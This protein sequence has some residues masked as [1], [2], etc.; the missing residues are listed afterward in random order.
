MPKDKSKSINQ[1]LDFDKVKSK[2]LSYKNKRVAVV[3]LG[4]TG[5]ALYRFLKSRG[6]KV[7]GLDRDS[8]LQCGIQNLILGEDYLKNL[9]QFDIIFVS[10]GVPLNLPEL[11]N[12]K[13]RG[14]II[15]SEI[16]L[17]FDLCPAKIIGITGTNGKTTTVTLLGKLLKARKKE[18]IWIGG[19]IGKPLIDKLDKIKKKDLV[20]LELSSFQLEN[21]TK[22]PFI[23]CILNITPDHLDR[24]PDFTS[25]L[26]AKANIFKY[27]NP[28]EFSVF[29]FDDPA[30]VNL[31]KIASSKVIFTSLY[32]DL[33]KG[34]FK[35]DK[36]IISTIFKRKKLAE[37]SDLKLPGD[38][39]LSNTLSALAIL[40]LIDPKV[41]PEL[42]RRV[43]KNFKGLEHRI[44]F[45]KE[46]K[47]V[48]YFN[49][50]KATTPASTI[51]ALKAF[52]EPVILIAGG[53]DK[54]L[55]FSE[56]AETIIEKVKLLI[57]IGKAAK[58]IKRALKFALEK[59]GL[60]LK[61]FPHHFASDLKEAVKLAKTYSK[62]GDI[63]LFSPGCASF[64]MFLNY[65]ERGRKFKELV[66]KK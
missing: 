50:S 28:E 11:E 19:N 36:E 60:D 57:L 21:L 24:H 66:S 30:C 20:V 1:I 34:V 65:E 39:N 37:V 48:R 8:K 43:L 10:P 3:G 46:I 44:E 55:D 35:K 29:N 18:K 6:A 15:S 13:K 38:H 53:L 64:D 63:V 54:N 4:R 27:Q 59:I 12:A 47:G 22:S 32:S 51:A 31:A 61:G 41:S 16:Q 7:Y 58:K 42:I 49:D 33:D 14:Q 2:P 40:E 9:E 45:V 26:E 62:K 17:F 23:A 56:L 52:D 25:Y 5:I